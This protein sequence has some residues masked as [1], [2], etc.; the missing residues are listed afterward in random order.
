MPKVDLERRRDL[1]VE[2]AQRLVTIREDYP[3]MILAGSFLMHLGH[4]IDYYLATRPRYRPDPAPEQLKVALND[5]FRKYLLE[6]RISTLPHLNDLIHVPEDAERVPFVQR[7]TWPTDP[8][9]RDYGLIVV[10]H[11]S[12]VRYPP[13]HRLETQRQ[14]QFSYD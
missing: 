5:L 11:N 8:K 2:A 14:H 10:T 4:D 13:I 1:I 6:R 12:A 9:G 3:L 7:R